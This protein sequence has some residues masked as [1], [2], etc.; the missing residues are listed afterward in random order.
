MCRFDLMIRRLNLKRL[1]YAFR[2][3]AA[4]STA[5]E[6]ALIAAGLSI[7]IVTAVNG[8][9]TG[10]KTSYGSVSTSRLQSGRRRGPGATPGLRY[11]GNRNRTGSTA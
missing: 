4:A 9:G 8:L 6:Y 2:G 10:L 11:F 1:I 5:I 7:A 3:D